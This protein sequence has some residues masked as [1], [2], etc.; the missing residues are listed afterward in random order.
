M[1]DCVFVPYLTVCN[2]TVR[3][4]QLCQT[5]CRRE[6]ETIKDL[7]QVLDWIELNWIE[8]NWIE[9]DCI[10]FYSILFSY[11]PHVLTCH[12]YLHAARLND[13]NSIDNTVQVMSNRND[14]GDSDSRDKEQDIGM[15]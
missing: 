8:L 13:F 5:C 7:D 9:L 12:F 3:S 1:I 10:V 15:R 14:N 2:Y 4:I 6:H 11:I